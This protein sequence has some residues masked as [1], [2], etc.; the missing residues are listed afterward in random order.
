VN[1]FSFEKTAAT[2][3]ARQRHYARFW[4]TTMTTEE[5]LSVYVGTAGLDTWHKW[6]VIHRTGPDVNEEREVLF[7]D[8]QGSGR[9]KKWQK[10]SL[11]G[12]TIQDQSFNRPLITDGTAYVISF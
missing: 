11:K 3:G 1:D 5:G 4:K 8:L 9:V 6:G 2:P 12:K 7:A 10:I